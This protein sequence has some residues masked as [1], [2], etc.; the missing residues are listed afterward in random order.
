MQSAKRI[1]KSIILLF[2]ALAYPPTFADAEEASVAIEVQPVEAKVVRRSQSM[3]VYLLQ[4]TAGDLPPENRLLLLHNNEDPL[5]A[6]RILR[7]DAE[8]KQMAVRRIKHYG[9]TKILEPDRAVVGRWK[10]RELAPPTAEVQKQD[11]KDLKE[12]DAELDA[13]IPAPTPELR[14]DTALDDDSAESSEPNEKITAP[15]PEADDPP[16]LDED[17]D[18]EEIGPEDESMENIA[19]EDT[20]AHDPD[21]HWLGGQLGY[22]L[23]RTTTG[24]ST[25][26]VGGGGRYGFTYAKNILFSGSSIQDGW[27]LEAG[28]FVY[29]VLNF[30]ISGDTYTV[31]PLTLVNRFDFFLSPD[32]FFFL[33]GG[34]HQ[35]IPIG[36]AQG[37]A[38]GRAALTLLTPT[39][40]G[41]L[42]FRF[43]PKWFIRADVG[44]DN[45]SVGLAL[46]F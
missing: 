19:I 37:T 15:L 3:R 45:I 39:G 5:M 23:A 42:G 27:T 4:L 16:P 10:I 35:S 6:L 46:R 9:N 18:S 2:A 41:G 12:L 30:A 24:A 40:G 13:G 21:R 17:L 36:S 31:L 20:E 33:Y 28:F 44:Y 32:F 8:K 43:G 29:K 11:E 1:L 22:V 25:Y 34:I 7:S 14:K 38:A 26:Y